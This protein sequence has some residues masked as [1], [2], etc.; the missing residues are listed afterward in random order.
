[1]VGRVPP[2]YS[3]TDNPATTGRSLGY[4][5]D[6]TEWLPTGP[7]TLNLTPLK[8]VSLSPPGFNQG[9]SVGYGA[10]L[11][12]PIAFLNQPVPVTLPLIGAISIGTALIAALV[13]FVAARYAVKK[14]IIRLE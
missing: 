9:R 14:E 8:N 2:G 11:Q 13:A 4:G 7:D 12:Y 10:D 3:I 1:M 5:A 6:N